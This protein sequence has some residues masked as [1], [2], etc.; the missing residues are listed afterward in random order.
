MTENV[1]WSDLKLATASALMQP[2]TD[3]V[4][5]MLNTQADGQ[6]AFTALITFMGHTLGGVAVELGVTP[7]AEQTAAVIAQTMTASFEDIL[8][9]PVN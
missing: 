2:L 5:G 8:A 9:D 3:W 1:D 4:D 6:A 7:S